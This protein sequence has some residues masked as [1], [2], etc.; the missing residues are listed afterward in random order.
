MPPPLDAGAA[1]RGDGSLPAPQR[2]RRRRARRDDRRAARRPT[3]S[4]PGL[5]AR[6]AAGSGRADRRRPAADRRRRP[7]R[8][9]RAGAGRGAARRW[10]AGGPSSP[11][12]RSSPTRTPAAIARGARARRSSGASAP[13]PTRARRWGGRERRAADPGDLAAALRR[14]RGRGRGGRPIPPPP[15]R[16][17]SSWPASAA[18]W[19]SAPVRITFCGTHGPGGTL[20]TTLDDGTGRRGGRGRDP[21]LLRPRLPV[22]PPVPLKSRAPAPGTASPVSGR[23]IRARLPRSRHAPRPVRNRRRL[24]QPGRQP[25][26]PRPGGRLA[27]AGLLDLGR[28]PAPDRRPGADHDRDGRCR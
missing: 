19:R 26:D 15:S 7:Q 11:A 13:P 8:A 23:T 14:G 16:G 24:A 12:S 18:G 3:R 10:P 17:R 1:A 27:L 28:R 6:G 4:P 9:G 25:A 21:R 20:R 5:G 22:R 2:R